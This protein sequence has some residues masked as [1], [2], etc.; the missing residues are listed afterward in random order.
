MTQYHVNLFVKFRRRW[1]SFSLRSLFVLVTVVCIYLFWAMNWIH[2][3]REFLL[4]QPVTDNS[5]VLM[6][7]LGE[8]ERPAPLLLRILGERGVI[9]IDINEDFFRKHAEKQKLAELNETAERLFP[10]ATVE[11]ARLVR[12]NGRDEW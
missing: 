10:E 9:R 11:T 5:E 2:Q 8:E 6:L 4:Q 7:L 1:L 3:R 12:G